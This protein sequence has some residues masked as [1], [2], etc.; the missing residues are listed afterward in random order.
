MFDLSN[1]LLQND[2]PCIHILHDLLLK[3]FE[4]LLCSF[5]KPGVVTSV[6]PILSVDFLDRANKKD[7]ANFNIGAEGREYSENT[8]KSW[9]LQ[10][11][12]IM[13]EFV[14]SPSVPI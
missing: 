7:Y 6:E 10:N 1:K 9:T 3:L 14:K 8:E 12:I 5:A 2:K 11:F 13:S 4:K